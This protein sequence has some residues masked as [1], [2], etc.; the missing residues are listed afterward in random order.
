MK[1]QANLE[2]SDEDAQ[3]LQSIGLSLGADGKMDEPK[4]GYSRSERKAIMR[5]A[6]TLLVQRA[7]E[8]RRS[9]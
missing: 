2:L 6:V 1:L 7:I 4:R 9:R 3:E 5:H 8:D